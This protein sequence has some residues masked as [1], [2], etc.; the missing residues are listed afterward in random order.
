[1]QAATWL[2]TVA[3]RQIVA[4]NLVN[5]LPLIYNYIAQGIGPTEGLRQYREAGGAI[6]TQRWFA[7]FGETQLEIAT[8]G[9]VQQAASDRPP[10]PD[11]ITPRQST[12][13]GGYLYRTGVLVSRTAVDPITGASRE[14]TSIEWQS[15]RTAQLIDYAAAQLAA[16]ANFGVGG[17]A[18]P[19]GGSVV[20][21]FVSAVNELVPEE[22]DLQVIT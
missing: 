2:P 17:D 7:A 11:E 18:G 21:S 14:V 13:P 10:N 12:K 8:S 9:I 15:I 22:P 20:G 16:E 5:P 6:R 1:M 19:Y 3:G 4:G